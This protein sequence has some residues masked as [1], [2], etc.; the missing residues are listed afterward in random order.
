MKTDHLAQL[1][2]QLTPRERVPLIM[3]AHLRGDPAEQKRLSA[4]APQQTFR[5]PD[6]FPLAK[7]LRDAARFHMLTLL[8]LAGHFW[9]WWGLW[10]SYPSPPDPDE[11][12]TR[13]RRRG[14]AARTKAGRRG[15]A[16]AD[17]VQEYRARGVTRYYASRF[18]AHLEGWKQFCSEL[19]VDSEASLKIMIGWGLVT[20][21][22]KAARPLVFT[23]AEAARF[24]GLETVTIEGVDTQQRCPVLIE[25][26]AGLV[27][28]WHVVL[29]DLVR[30]E[31]GQCGAST[32]P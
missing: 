28:D 5:V 11:R 20:Q 16:D 10:M 22:E 6:Y 24:E 29:E 30:R 18:V 1:Y 3:A 25:S 17:F 27:Q 4:S 7:A 9:Q 15:G 2:D 13:G 23:A 19:H 31:G 26:V 14:T 8:D 12:V 32:H 21:T